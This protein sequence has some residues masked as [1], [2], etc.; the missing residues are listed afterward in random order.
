MSSSKKIILSIAVPIPLNR[1][2]DYL[3]PDNYTPE[4]LQPGVRVKIPFGKNTKTGVLLAIKP[5]STIDTSKLKKA[6]SI[7]DTYPLLSSKDLDLLYWAQTY[8]HHPIG[9]VFLS[10]FPIALRK[11]KSS[12][13][14]VPHYYKLTGTGKDINEQ[15][16]KNA[17]KQLALLNLLQT[18]QQAISSQEIANYF[19]LWRAP[20]KA[21]IDKKYVT[22]T[23]TDHIQPAIITRQP[24]L[25][26]NP[27]QLTAID[28]V[29]TQLDKFSVHL[30]EGVTGS[31][32]TEVYLQIIHQVLTNGL[33]VLVL[34]PEITLTPQLEARF[35]QRFA[36]AIETY[37]SQHNET[38]R[39]TAWVNMQQG[40]SAI[41]LGTRSA[42]LTP[43]PR[44]GLI[45]LDEEHDSSFKQQEGFRFSA[46]DVAIVRA[47]M[48]DIPVI[49]GSATPSLESLYNAQKK[50]YQLLKLPNRAGNATAPK[51]SLLDIRNQIL[52]EGLSPP[53]IRDIHK[54]LVKNE[55]V[56]LFLNRRG[57]APTLICH[58]CGWVA[59]CQRCDA[60]LVV[61]HHQQKLRCHHCA[62]EQRLP[63]QCP[64]CTAEELKPLGL[65]TERVENALHTLFPGKSIVRLDSDSTQ[66]KGALEQHLQ[67]INQGEVDIILGT[68]MLAKGH[69]FPNVTLAVLLDVDSGLFSIDFHAPERLAQLITQVSGRAGRAEKKGLVIMQTRQPE[70]PLLNTLIHQGYQAFAA[71]ALVERKA[72]NL[73]PYSFQALLRANAHETQLPLDF[74]SAVANLVNQHNNGTL[75]LGPVPAPMAKR[76]GQYR[77]Q[78]LLQHT[79]RKQLHLL[80]N[81]LM[82]EIERLK[83]ARKIRWSLDV[84]PIDLY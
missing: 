36:V 31:G 26:A 64:G 83:Q 71:A 73:P 81:W 56:L 77:Y 12:K 2:F 1:V 47:K 10:A 27:E 41:L 38:Q 30:L 5:D 7:L 57:F 72:A 43:L 75:A 63:K 62:S 21:L 37:H 11:G 23:S 80:L 32:K 35:R 33:Q 24:A 49:L 44:P 22:Q 25:Q 76:A 46:R 9:D 66:K 67:A 6:E 51:L 34:L 8:Y 4:H 60:N 54:T 14:K 45:I 82:P 19:K 74:L 79:Q 70:H 50:R 17:P 16:L 29:C 42:L 28:S 20:L 69:H 59:Q 58:S 84:D 78:L 13:L 15:A 39:L 40:N 65:G 52:Q 53:L 68:Q 3:P 55:Q 18:Q 61:H 48:L